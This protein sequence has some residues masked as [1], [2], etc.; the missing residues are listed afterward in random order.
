MEKE[1]AVASLGQSTLLLSLLKDTTM[2]P[3]WSCCS[4]PK[5]SSSS[6]IRGG[7]PR[8]CARKLKPFT[9]AH[10]NMLQNNPDRVRSYFGDPK[11]KML[12]DQYFIVG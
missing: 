10:M 8:C 3:W 7:T 1:N 12:P 5:R 11:V 6:S 9:T 4:C 2:A